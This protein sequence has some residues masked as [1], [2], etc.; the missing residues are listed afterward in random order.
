MTGSANRIIRPTDFK[1]ST[2]AH[3]TTQ[4][5]F[6]YPEKE[7]YKDRN[8]MYRVSS[9]TVDQDVSEFTALPDYER[10]LMPLD[11]NLVLDVEGHKT[12]IEPFEIIKFDGAKKVISEGRVRDL[13]LMI[14]KGHQ[15]RMEVM[16]DILNISLDP[17]EPQMVILIEEDEEG[18]FKAIKEVR[19]KKKG[20]KLYIENSHKFTAVIIT[21]C[22]AEY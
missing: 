5:I 17:R 1:V 8:F 7:N 19:I 4:E 12:T 3:G 21:L 13:N 11:G 2:W 22:D 14:R 6:I 15:G 10:L 18:R 9:A 20:E 16:T